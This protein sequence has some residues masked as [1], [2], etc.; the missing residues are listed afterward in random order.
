[1]R[2]CR[3]L[4]FPSRDFFPSPTFFVISSYS[5]Y[6]FL[7]PL[8]RKRCRKRLYLNFTKNPPPPWMIFSCLSYF[9]MPRQRGSIGVFKRYLFISF[10]LSVFSLNHPSQQISR[11]HYI[12]IFRSVFYKSDFFAIHFMLILKIFFLQPIRL[13]IFKRIIHV[14]T[15]LSLWTG[16]NILA[17][18]LFCPNL[19]LENDFLLPKALKL[20]SEFFL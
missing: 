11:S 17:L 9:S 1:M 3:Y 5:L 18:F 15:P 12:L 19:A 14:L 16:I 8:I 2:R 6:P 10:L 4:I 20:K 7:Y 13:F